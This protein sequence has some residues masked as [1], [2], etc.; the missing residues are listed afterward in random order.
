[1]AGEQQAVGQAAGEAAAILDGPGDR[2]TAGDHSDP[3]E[4]HADQGRVVLHGEW[5][6]DQPGGRVDGHCD[7]DVLVRVDPHCH[8]RV[9]LLSAVADD[10]T[11]ARALARGQTYCE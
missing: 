3:L 10:G 8:H 11:D 7:V 6:A 4:Q 5:P 2:C 1:V 9:V